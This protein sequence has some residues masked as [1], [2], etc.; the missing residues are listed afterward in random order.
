DHLY[1]EGITFRNTRTAI[2]AGKKGIAGAEGLTVKR[3]RFEDV[4]VAIHTD[5]SGSKNFYVADNVIIGR[6]DPDELFGWL[7]VWPWSGL[8]RFDDRRR[9]RSYYAVA[10][11]GSGHVIAHNRVSG[12]HDAIDH[13]TYGMPDGYPDV[14][15]D[16]MPVSIDIYGN[17]VSNVHD[18]C[19]EAD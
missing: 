2:E 11:Y 4:G 14:P 9:L 13:A 5:W 12:F 16:R 17:D 19:F 1:F 7:D 18:N 15:R 3:S 8:P 6:N 10:I